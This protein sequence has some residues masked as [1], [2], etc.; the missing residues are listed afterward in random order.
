MKIKVE[1]MPDG[2]TAKSLNPFG[3]MDEWCPQ[4]K[5]CPC[6]LVNDPG[7]NLYQV[8]SNAEQERKVYE[9]EKAIKC[10]SWC[11]DCNYW[12]WSDCED[13]Y[14]KFKPGTIHDAEIID[15]KTVRII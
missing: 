2:I 15:E 3:T 9:I 6:D 4:C 8:Y 11:G 7:C 10:F 1:I 14:K 12:D 13:K 5:N